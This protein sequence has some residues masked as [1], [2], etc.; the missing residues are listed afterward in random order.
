MAK[1]NIIKELVNEEISLTVAL[2]RLIVLANDIG[3][4]ELRQWAEKETNGYGP[5]D[6][7]PEYRYITSTSITYNGVVGGRLSVTHASLDLSLLNS[8]TRNEIIRSRVNESISSIEKNAKLNEGELAIDRSY[9]AGEVFA[10]SGGYSGVQCTKITQNFT[11]SQFE[12]IAQ[13]VSSKILD[14]LLKLDKEFGN[15]D[16]LDIGSDK[17]SKKKFNEIKQFILV[18]IN[19]DKSVNMNGKTKITNSQINAGNSNKSSNKKEKKITKNSNIGKGSNSVEKH[20]DIDS[21]VTITNQKEKK[22]S[23]WSKIFH[24]RS[25]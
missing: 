20:T 16:N 22:D 14:I 5:K 7:V 17:I 4:T 10:N 1:S 25:K 11:P 12:K 9:L 18:V 24:K 3:Y 21:N 19:E 13:A 8:K 2:K 23:F 6:E 15:L